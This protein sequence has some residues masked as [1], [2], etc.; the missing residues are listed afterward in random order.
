MHKVTLSNGDELLILPT[1]SSNMEMQAG[2]RYSKIGT[3]T[4]HDDRSISVDFEPEWVQETHPHLTRKELFESFL[5]SQLPL[6]NP[7]GKDAP[8]YDVS[9]GNSWAYKLL[10]WKQAESRIMKPGKYLCI[11]KTK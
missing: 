2:V 10:D 3:L 8:K 6:V 9:R 1:G 7:F 11:I 5:Q 4:V